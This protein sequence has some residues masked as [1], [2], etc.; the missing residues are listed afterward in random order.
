ML[1]HGYWLTTYLRTLMAKSL[2]DSVNFDF[3]HKQ[4]F[5]RKLGHVT[6][7]HTYVV[8]KVALWANVFFLVLLRQYPF[9]CAKIT[10]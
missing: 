2:A 10:V 7:T 5:K 8:A 3:I 9:D 6:A 1:Q 4:V